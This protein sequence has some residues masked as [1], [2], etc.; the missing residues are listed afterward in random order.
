M[1]NDMCC[2]TLKCLCYFSRRA[3][4]FLFLFPLAEKKKREKS[5]K[6]CGHGPDFSEQPHN[7]RVN[8][9]T[10]I[11]VCNVMI[12]H[13]RSKRKS[14]PVSLLFCSKLIHHTLQTYMVTSLP[15][16]PKIND[17]NEMGRH[18]SQKKSIHMDVRTRETTPCPVFFVCLFCF[19]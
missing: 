13:C 9:P 4:P 17:S 7:L 10:E 11:N 2:L 6:A 1:R 18:G 5:D 19:T 14:F 12:Q 8:F 15:S 16:K 3:L